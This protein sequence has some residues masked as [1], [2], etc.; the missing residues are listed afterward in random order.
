MRRTRNETVLLTG[1]TG[2]LGHYVLAEFLARGFRCVVLLR[3]PIEASIG[4]LA[5]LLAELDVDA[6]RHIADGSIEPIS[7]EL[8][9]RLPHV[10][11]DSSAVLIHAAAAT[12]FRRNAS[13]DPERT[14]VD[15]FPNSNLL[16]PIPSATPLHLPPGFRT[17]IREVTA[18]H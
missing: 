9:D 3:P 4:R 8:P 2:F 7:A 1:A 15:V 16:S 12:N 11:V 5:N 10:P 17:S 14:N 13:G 18:S 6:D